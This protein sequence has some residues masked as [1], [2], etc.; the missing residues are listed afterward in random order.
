MLL[1]LPLLVLLLLAMLIPVSEGYAPSKPDMPP[2]ASATATVCS[3]HPRM[4]NIPAPVFFFVFFW[5]VVEWERREW[6]S[7][8]DRRGWLARMADMQDVCYIL[9]RRR[10]INNWCRSTNGWIGVRGW[11]R[12]RG[13]L[14]YMPGKYSVLEKN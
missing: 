11:Q 8:G 2:L 14:P 12:G 9:L 3:Y 5:R 4:L 10:E 1:L 7:R 6:E 13:S